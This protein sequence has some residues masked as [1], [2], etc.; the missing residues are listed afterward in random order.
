M[1]SNREFNLLMAYFR[2][3]VRQK[4]ILLMMVAFPT[5]FLLAGW[6]SAETTDLSFGL[7]GQLITAPGR[8]VSVMSMVLASGA[9]L[10]AFICFYVIITTRKNDLRLALTGFSRLQI[11]G[12]KLATISI[13]LFPSILYILLIAMIMV[14]I[15]SMIFV[16]IA[17][18]LGTLN[19]ALIGILF[20]LIF[21]NELEATYATLIIVVSD[22]GFLENP[23]FSTLYNEPYMI[24]APGYYPSKL[25]LE[26]SFQEPLNPVTPILF[27][28]VYALVLL[29]IITLIFLRRTRLASN[30]LRNPQ[31]Y[32]IV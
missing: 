1:T 20:G 21:R 26:A 18:S 27:A 29:I 19:Y 24:L 4:S 8:S 12:A 11:L 2:S 15:R 9:F 25:L 31:I 22:V 13:L 10:G 32:S 23:A 5:I 7:N 16:G 17:F 3:L 6:V 30:S 14:E 28:L